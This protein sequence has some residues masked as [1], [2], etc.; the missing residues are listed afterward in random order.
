MIMGIK[1]PV[2]FNDRFI[3]P[4]LEQ[5]FDFFPDF[6]KQYGK[7]ITFQAYMSLILKELDNIKPNGFNGQAAFDALCFHNGGINWFMDKYSLLA[8][9]G[10]KLW[11]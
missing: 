11:T 10:K 7:P 5:V 3:P 1:L 4:D 9:A 8:G 2:E 6:A